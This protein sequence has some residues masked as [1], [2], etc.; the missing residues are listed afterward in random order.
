M[1]C[2]AC[3]KTLLEGE[4][5]RVAQWVFCEDCFQRLL[6]QPSVTPGTEPTAAPPG[7]ASDSE[8]EVSRVA[9]DGIGEVP[10]CHLCEAPLT[11]GAAWEIG[12]WAFC[13]ACRRSLTSPTSKLSG[14]ADEEPG[15]RGPTSPPSEAEESTPKVVQTRVGLG[16]TALC[17]RCGKRILERAGKVLEGELLCP[18]CYYSTPV[19][20]VASS[21]SYSSSNRRSD[22]GL[23]SEQAREPSMGACD[24]CGKSV[25]SDR[26]QLVSGFNLCSACVATD[27]DLALEIA[28]G[29]HRRHLEALKV[30][31]AS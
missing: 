28:R 22:D 20:V 14:R 15:S 12:P 8:S 30:R 23:L 29:R 10:R 7:A 6:R 27:G 18:D 5:R 1:N 9:T 11:S 4:E 31:F 26:L 13:D 2:R 25:P 16:R 24:S 21:S 17:A 3:E 19:P